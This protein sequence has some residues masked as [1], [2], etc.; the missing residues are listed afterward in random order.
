MNA[1]KLVGA[2][3]FVVGLILLIL[4][5]AADIF[6]IGENP[7]MFGT[8]QIGGSIIGAAG[9]AIGLVLLLK[10]SPRAADGESGTSN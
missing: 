2:L 8:W 6:G 3:C 10:K 7:Y 4:F 9:I 1:S 5:A